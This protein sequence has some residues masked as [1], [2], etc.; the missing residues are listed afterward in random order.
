[1]V[2]SHVE[3]GYARHHVKWTATEKVVAREAFDLALRRELDAVT[4]EAK[5]MAAKI[6]QPSELWELE[7]YLTKRRTEIDRLYDYRYSVLPI[8]FCELIRKGRLKEE[9]LQGLREDK[10]I[11]IRMSAA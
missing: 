10:M 11:H 2:I 9:D 3:D 7:R 8:V 1:M 5:S 6:Q 4:R